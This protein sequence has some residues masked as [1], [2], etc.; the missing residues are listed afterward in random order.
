MTFIGRNSRSNPKS[1]EYLENGTE[2]RD[3]VHRI[4]IGVIYGLSTGIKFS[5]PDD[6]CGQRSRSNLENCDL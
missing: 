5:I 6:L 4:Q 3:G 2:K 1:F